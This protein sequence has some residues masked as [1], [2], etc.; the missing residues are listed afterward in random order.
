MEEVLNDGNLSDDNSS[1]DFF[2]QLEADVNS[3]II[4]EIDQPE[5]VTPVVNMAP[6]TQETQTEPQGSNDNDGWE[7]RYKDSSREAQRLHSELNE[8]KPFV[9]VLEAMKNDSGLVSHVRNYFEN[10]GSPDDSIT[11]RLGLDEDFVYDQQEAVTD[12][13]S[14]SAK[15]FNAYVQNAVEHRVQGAISEEKQKNMQIMKETE[16]QQE[17][18]DFRV[19]H[20]LSEEQFQDFVGKAQ[21]HTL[22]LDDAYYL[23]NRGEANANV[24]Q[25]TKKDMLNQM[26]GVRDIPTSAS[27]ANSTKVEQSQDSQIFDSLLGSDGNLDDLFG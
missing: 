17:E 11:G 13:N 14:D 19:K 18:R 4:D 2:S 1:E 27:N 5:E 12:P 9:P 10:G 8:L 24:A 26:K 25:E 16:K 22:T 23:V 6:E 20:G 15:V 7:K 21:S 3:G